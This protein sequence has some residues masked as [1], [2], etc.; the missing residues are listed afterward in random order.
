[1]KLSS[2]VRLVLVAAATAGV[3]CLARDLAGDDFDRT[4]FWKG[5]A[6]AVLLQVPAAFL[7]GFLGAA[8][9][10]FKRWRFRKTWDRHVTWHSPLTTSTAVA[11]SSLSTT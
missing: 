5:V 3:V 7:G 6:F 8:W 9:A 11:P 10:A 1:M 4:A 2:V